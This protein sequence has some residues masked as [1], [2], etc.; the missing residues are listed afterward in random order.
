MPII[1][2]HAN[3]GVEKCKKRTSDVLFRPG[4][5]AAFEDKV[6]KYEIFSKCRMQ[7]AR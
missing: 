5:N 6:L 4:M 1:F 2:Y 3:L 7:N